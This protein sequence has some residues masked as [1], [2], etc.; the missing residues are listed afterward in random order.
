VLCALGL[1]QLAKLDRFAAR[2]RTLAAAYHLALAD[3][4]PL[5]RPAASPAWSQAVPHLMTVLIDFE[6]AGRDRLAVVEALRER[7]VGSQVHYIPVH[8]QPYY[9]A[10]YGALALPGAEAWYARCLSLPLYPAMAEADV[11]RVVAALRAALGL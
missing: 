4:A 6:A 8:R 1:S 10:R 2:R 5:V 7:G 11:A 9:A 3:L